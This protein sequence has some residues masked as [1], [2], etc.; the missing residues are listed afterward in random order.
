M[1]ATK[2]LEVF[3]RVELLVNNAG[4]CQTASIDQTSVDDYERLMQTNFVGAM[5]M[6]KALLP[7]LKASRGTIVNV[8]SFGGVIPLRGMS[9]YTASK[10]A[11]AGWS[12]ALRTEL[13]PTGVHV[14]QV[15]PGVIN[16]EWLERAVFEK[17]D[18]AQKMRE[19][20]KLPG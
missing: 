10:F 14:A 15:H 18:G 2:T 4:V 16:S 17:D 5:R 3:E 6:T 12:E 19:T 9:A 7:A 8:N 13:E 20:L 11:L 1:L